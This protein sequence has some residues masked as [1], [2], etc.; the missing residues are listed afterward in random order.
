MEKKT[1]FLSIEKTPQFIEEI[2]ILQF[3][4]NKKEQNWYLKKKKTTGKEEFHVIGT[5][6]WW[7]QLMQT[8]E[9]NAEMEK[10]D[11]TYYPPPTN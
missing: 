3:I 6:F 8:A 10:K 4:S 2:N 7:G 5:K 9:E 11:K 1:W